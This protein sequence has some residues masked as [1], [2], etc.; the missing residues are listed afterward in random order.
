[1]ALVD[2]LM[3]KTFYFRRKDIINNPC[4]IALLLQKYPYLGTEC[5][6]ITIKLNNILLILHYTLAIM[7]EMCRIKSS[8]VN[9]KK[10]NEMLPKIW[11]KGQIECT[12]S[13]RVRKALSDSLIQGTCMWI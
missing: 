10:W 6:V 9:T 2:D 4:G 7:K 13:S 12:M 8:D 5:Q 3:E 11:K 1:M